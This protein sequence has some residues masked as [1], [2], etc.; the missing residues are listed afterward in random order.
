MSRVVAI[1]GASAGVGRATA[2]A[3]AARGDRVALIARGRAGLAAAAREVAEAGGTPLELALDVADAAAVEAAAQR[4]EDELGPLDVWV[5]NAMTAVLAEVVDTTPEEFRRVTEVTYLGSVHGAQAALRRM[6][7]RDRGTI[8]QVGS[9]LTRRGIPLQ[10]TYCGAK[11]ALD[12]FVDSLRT[13]LLHRGSQVHLTLVQLPGLNTTQFTWVRARTPREPMPVPPIYAPELAARAIV[14][15]AEHRRRELWVGL[16]TALTLLGQRV[17]PWLADRRLA[18]AGY[19]SQQSG[20]PLEPGRPD[21]VF[22]PLDDARDHGVH[23]P[24]GAQAHRR[25][26][27]LGL[28]THR[29]PALGALAAAAGAAAGAGLARRRRG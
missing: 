19:A 25:D 20:A 29:G 11:H 24:F 7:P 13:E 28:G 26:P 8:V 12:G 21:Y 4:I 27:Q 16:P 5:N 1:T 17:A 18:R 2:R 14:W 6:L 22:A 10:A 9:A 23:G 15:A 3:F